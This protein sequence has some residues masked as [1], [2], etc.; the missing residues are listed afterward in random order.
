[1]INRKMTPNQ[2][3][4][5][6]WQ[7]RKEIMSLVTEAE[8]LIADGKMDMSSDSGVL[9]CVAKFNKRIGLNRVLTVEQ[10]WQGDDK[11]RFVLNVGVLIHCET[12]RK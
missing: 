10:V 6:M 1:M 9:A 3:K 11:S 12:V 2:K 7:I 8:T 4:E 5:R